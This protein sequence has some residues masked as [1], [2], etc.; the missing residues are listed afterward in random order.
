M[1]SRLCGLIYNKSVLCFTASPR[2]IKCSDIAVGRA[3]GITASSRK[4]QLAPGNT[5]REDSYKI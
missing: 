3:G 1:Q 5:A 4:R 2:E